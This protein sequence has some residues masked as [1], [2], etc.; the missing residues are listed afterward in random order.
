MIHSAARK[1][2]LDRLLEIKD[3]IPQ[4]ITENKAHLAK[5][6]VPF[7]RFGFEPNQTMVRTINLGRSAS[8]SG[9][10]QELSGL[11]RLS[12]FVPA[13]SGVDLMYETASLI[14][15]Q[16]PASTSA[17]AG[18]D[19]VRI[20]KSWHETIREDAEWPHLPVFVR[21]L[22]HYREE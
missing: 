4:V 12:V 11:L 14:T 20:I 2:L 3:K 6:R 17:Y 18:T 21:W 7:V 15:K 22:V 8:G 9:P 5:D 16:F 13:A 1:I 19:T 10:I